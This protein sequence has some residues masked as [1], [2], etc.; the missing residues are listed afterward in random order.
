MVS[1]SVKVPK[2]TLLGVIG[3]QSIAFVFCV[4]I[5]GILTAVA[6][7]TW[8]KFERNGDRV[9]ARAQV[10]LFFVVPY[11][12]MV[13]D[14]VTGFDNREVAG[15]ETR[16]RRRGQHDRVTTSED[17]GF[18]VIQGPDQTAQVS[19]TPV[20]LKSV[21]ERSEAFLSDPQA[22]ELKLFVVANWKFSVIAGGLA[23]L[24]AAF[25]AVCIVCW[26]FVTIYRSLRGGLRYA[27]GADLAVENFHEDSSSD[28]TEKSP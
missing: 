16:Q 2:T 8:V 20:D 28:N 12:T 23:S 26:I 15:S 18:L 9:T 1:Q 4:V 25:Y 6:P 10:C 3:S 27:T 24:L 7:V 21:T 5:P 14:P 19:V 22:T 11:K 17:Q 13:V